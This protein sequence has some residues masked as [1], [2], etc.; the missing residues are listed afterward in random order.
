MSRDSPL[1]VSLARTC[2]RDREMS[3][4]IFYSRNVATI[5]LLSSFL[6]SLLRRVVVYRERRGSRVDF[7][8]DTMMNAAMSASERE[9]AWFVA[10]RARA[11]IVSYT[12]RIAQKLGFTRFRLSQPLSRCF[13]RRTRERWIYS[14]SISCDF[15]PVNLR[16]RFAHAHGFL[17]ENLHV[18]RLESAGVVWRKKILA[19]TSLMPRP[20]IL[21][22]A[23][24]SLPSVEGSVKGAKGAIIRKIST[25]MPAPL[26]FFSS[27]CSS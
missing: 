13:S 21:R 3:F 24:L 23:P 2:L 20:V 10:S 6:R 17:G 15:L 18:F 22:R 7:H 1:R 8:R 25:L 27:A 16:C 9:T 26:L 4:A 5:R 12:C 11:R 19:L 14:R